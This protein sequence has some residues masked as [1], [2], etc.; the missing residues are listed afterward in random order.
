MRKEI[1]DTLAYRGSSGISYN[2]LCSKTASAANKPNHQ[3]CVPIRYMERALAI[4]PIADI[5]MLCGKISECINRA[6]FN[7]MGEI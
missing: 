5:R 3:T 6:N 1:W 7:V 2:K 4:V